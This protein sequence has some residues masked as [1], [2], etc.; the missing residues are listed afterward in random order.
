MKLIDCITRKRTIW[1]CREVFGKNK[2]EKQIRDYYTLT[3]TTLEIKL[4]KSVEKTLSMQQN[5]W[6]IRWKRW[7]P[8]SGS[9]YKLQMK[10]NVINKENKTAWNTVEQQGNWMWK[11]NICQDRTLRSCWFQFS[12]WRFHWHCS[13]CCLDWSV[14]DATPMCQIYVFVHK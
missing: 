13:G 9:R 7:T 8:R 4:E 10:I 1:V 3:K 6:Q 14:G 11:C 12:A 2:I 5:Y